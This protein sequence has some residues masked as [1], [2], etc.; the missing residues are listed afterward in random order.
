MH[1]A[2]STARTSLASQWAVGEGIPSE[3]DTV[4]SA[5]VP[6]PGRQHAVEVWQPTLLAAA[7]Q[8]SA[9]RAVPRGRTARHRW[10]TTP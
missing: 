8:C 3:A 9:D 10:T 2:V 6:V 5:S 7:L 1:L 4:V